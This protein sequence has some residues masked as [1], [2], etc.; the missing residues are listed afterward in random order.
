MKI[1]KLE[2]ENK[3]FNEKFK[4]QNEEIESL[5]LLRDELDS[6]LKIYI[7]EIK[8]SKTLNETVVRLENE[9]CQLIEENLKSDQKLEVVEAKNRELLMKLNEEISKTKYSL[10][11][12]T[13]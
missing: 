12:I 4:L 6:Q 8:K 5:K 2:S 10:L 3:F 13:L 7:E 9:K 1:S 11:K